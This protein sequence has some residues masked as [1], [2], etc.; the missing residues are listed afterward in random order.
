MQPATLI[1]SKR[2]Y[3][4][5]NTAKTRRKLIPMAKEIMFSWPRNA[6]VAPVATATKEKIKPIADK[7]KKRILFVG[8]ETYGWLGKKSI[9]INES[10]NFDL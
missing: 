3:S 1:L 7:A 9:D 5:K 10:M 6:K 4:A 2:K 8:K